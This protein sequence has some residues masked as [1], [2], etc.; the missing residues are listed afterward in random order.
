MAL[1]ALGQLYLNS[2]FEPEDLVV[3][4][5]G[6]V[7]ELHTLRIVAILFTTQCSRL[8]HLRYREDNGTFVSLL[9]YAVLFGHTDLAAELAACGCTCSLGLVCFYI[10]PFQESSELWMV[11]TNRGKEQW[12]TWKAAEKIGNY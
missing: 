12:L 7:V 1:N 5:A 3:R 2:R 10:A 6:E 4:R 11:L 9:D 8:I